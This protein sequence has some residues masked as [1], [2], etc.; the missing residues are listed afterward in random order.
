MIK[1]RHAI[2]ALLTGL[3]FLNYID[4]TVLSAV[5]EHVERDLHL[6]HGAAGLGASAFIIGYAITAPY[7]GTRGDRGRRTGLIAAGVIVWSLATAATG[8]AH[9]LATFLVARA[10]VGVG[11]ASYATLAPTII[12]DL[13]PP[14]RK[15]RALAIFYLA[16]PLGSALGYMVGGTLDVHWG[17]HQAFYVVGIPG[18]VLALACLAIDEP[19]RRLVAA[20]AR[21]RDALGTLVRI[22]LYRRAVIGYCAYTAGVGAFA[23]WAPEFLVSRFPARLT[24]ES[25]GFW[26]GLVTVAGGTIATLIGGQWADRALR[27]LPAVAPDAPHDARDNRAAI[28]ALLRVCALGMVVATPLAAVCFF[29]PAP[30]GFFVVAL[31][32][33]L[34]VFVST[35][36]VNAIALRA[37]PAELRA[38]AMAAM[39]FAI[40]I[41]GDL[42]SP[43]VLGFVRDGLH[44]AMHRP[45]SDPLPTTITMML[46]PVLFA[47]TTIVWWPRRREAA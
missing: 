30:A 36:P 12:D 16:I 4:R 19:P 10:A 26:F 15:N 17:W 21:I 47:I 38:S 14:D 39:I 33:E 9:D 29:M 46:L 20:K 3:N 34:G 7:F 27:G 22:P 37:V 31:L 41:L 40:H 1:N 5:L 35:S 32:V 43:P 28:N 42:W 25:A 18:V 23:Y 44:V 24:T 8:L 11:E 6:S 45:E 13:T 2:L